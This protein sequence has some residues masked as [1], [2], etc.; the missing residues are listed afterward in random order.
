MNFIEELGPLA[1]GS[2]IKNLSELLMK[3]MSRVYKDHGI[4]FEAR[5]FTLF[6]LVLKREKISVTE[7]ASELNQSHPAVVQVV[8]VLE[9]KKL[10]S[11]V[12][13][14]SDHRRRLVKLSKN[15]KI[16]ANQLSS[17]WEDVLSVANEIINEGAPDLLEKISGLEKAIQ[18]KSV[19][20]R[21]SEKR[22]ARIVSSIEFKP[23]TKEFQDDFRRLNEDWLRSYLEITEHDRKNLMDPFGEIIGKDGLITLMVSAKQ[24]IGS[25]VLKRISNAECEL[26]KFTIHRNFRGI[27]L[28]KRMLRKALE[29]AR[30]TGYESMLLFTHHALVEA[31]QLYKSM[32]FE[33]IKERHDIVD[34]TGR[35]S[36]MMK[37]NIN[38]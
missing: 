29:E 6:Q 10:I 21:M 25:F 37:L 14:R 38:Q 1:L 9:K 20:E 34:E 12:K 31:T 27:G 24:P 18:G 35:C 15:G 5:W 28:G 4:E 16:L 36:M 2:R 7:I 23:F 3:D 19:Y 22:I 33:E 13:D 8:N 26:S 30:S 32:G 11:T 17:V